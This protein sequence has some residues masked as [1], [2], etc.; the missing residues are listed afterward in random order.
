MWLDHIHSRKDGIWLIT[1]K[2]VERAKYISTDEVLDSLVAYRWTERIRRKL[3]DTKSVKELV[4]LLHTRMHQGAWPRFA[5][6]SRI[7]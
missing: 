7:H 2:K 1:F 5:K 4:P 6:C 3:D